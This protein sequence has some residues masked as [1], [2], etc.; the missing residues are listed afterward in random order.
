M[1]AVVGELLLANCGG[2]VLDG[3]AGHCLRL[4]PAPEPNNRPEEKNVHSG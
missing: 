2:G 3:A 4:P 1:P